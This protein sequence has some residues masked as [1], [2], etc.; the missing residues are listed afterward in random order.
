MSKKPKILVVDDE[1]DVLESIQFRLSQDGYE[2]VTASNGHEALGAAR[3]ELPDLI[4]LD[5]MLPGENGYRVSRIIREDEDAGI[6]PRRAPIILLTARDLSRE[7]EREKTFLEFSRADLM[8]YKPFDMA[9]LLGKIREMLNS[10][11]ASLPS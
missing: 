11:V 10:G 5:V 3:I 8:M 7:P 9:E 4:I 2:V 1:P 6:Y